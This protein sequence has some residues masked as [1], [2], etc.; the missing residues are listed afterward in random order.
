MKIFFLPTL[1]NPQKLIDVLIEILN[2]CKNY[3]KKEE[4]KVIDTHIYVLYDIHSIIM[5]FVSTVTKNTHNSY[6]YVNF[7][8]VR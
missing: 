3:M 1:T 5:E 2:A 8:Q 4:I 7:L 6:G